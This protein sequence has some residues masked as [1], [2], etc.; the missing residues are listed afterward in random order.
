MA[1]GGT[2]VAPRVSW[3]LLGVPWWLLGLVA[4]G[5]LM[6]AKNNHGGSWA[7]LSEC[8]STLWLLESYMETI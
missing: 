5:I 2:L 1:P 8:L 4:G 7:Y 3:W 6:A